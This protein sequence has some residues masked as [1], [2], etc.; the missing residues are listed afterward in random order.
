VHELSLC[1][2]IF[3]IADR[4]RDGRSVDVIR[5]QVGQLRQVVP[6][7]LEYCWGLVVADTA[8]QGSRLDIEHVAVQL[9]CGD[10]DATTTAAHELVLTCS[11][12]GSGRVGV[13][14]GEEFMVISM[15]VGGAGDG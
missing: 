1:H 8:L 13:T 4:A 6:R 2:S 12:C 10:C 3:A 7:T 9:R 5:L 15:D 11:R 14:H